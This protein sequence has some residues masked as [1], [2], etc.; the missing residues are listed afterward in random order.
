MLA[1]SRKKGD[2][3]IIGD[4][5]EVIVLGV[6]GEQVKLGVV[7]PKS[8]PVHRKEIYELIQ[9]ENIKAASSKEGNIKKLYDIM[10]PSDKGKST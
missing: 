4:N 7:A 8:I 6:V 10:P 9:N 3:I 5:I 1:L 2:S